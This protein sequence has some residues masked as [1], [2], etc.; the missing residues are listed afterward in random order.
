MRVDAFDI[1]GVGATWRAPSSQA[2]VPCGAVRYS[3][4]S[5][6]EM[7]YSSRVNLRKISGAAFVGA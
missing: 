5:R 4:L 6:A 7:D 1:F 2:A 3:L